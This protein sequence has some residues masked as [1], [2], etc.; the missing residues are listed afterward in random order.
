VTNSLSKGQKT[1]HKPFKIQLPDIEDVSF[2]QYTSGSTSD[3]K[4]VKITW[5]NLIHQLDYNKKLLYLN[6]DSRSVLWVPHF[7]DFGLI[8]GILS[9]FAG[10][11]KLWMISPIDFVRKPSIWMEVMSRV[12]ATHTASP[13]FGYA[14]VLKKTTRE[15]RLLWDLSSL[16][17]FMSAAE[18]I[19]PKTMDMFVEAFSICDLKASGFCPS[20]G[21]A[22]HTVGVTIGGKK[23]IK[24]NK[25]YLDENVIYPSNR[26][27]ENNTVTLVGCGSVEKAKES[28]I[29][30]E[31]IN[32]NTLQKCAI[33]EVGEIWVNS[34]SKAAG[35]YNRPEIS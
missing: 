16:Q 21:L 13:N 9:V 32:P 24:F 4:G 25:I 3:P 1:K 20:Y 14:L 11:G 27:A 31:I 12:R 2:I 29:I 23:R 10:S 6:D 19:N 18:P 30:V 17:H 28:G 5:N 26:Q 33:N 7:H 15:M 35:Y 34:E 8:S 22:E